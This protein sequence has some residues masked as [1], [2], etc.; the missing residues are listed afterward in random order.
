MSLIPP[1]LRIV[2]DYTGEVDILSFKTT[3]PM[4]TIGKHFL[5]KYCPEIG[6]SRF[7]KFMSVSDF[8]RKWQSILEKEKLIIKEPFQVRDDFV[9]YL[10]KI[11]IN[12]RSVVIPK[13]EIKE[14]IKNRNTKQN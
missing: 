11:R 6:R 3:H 10:L 2:D 1:S 7:M 9:G 8:I 12:K 14:F 5:D 4:Y 13:A